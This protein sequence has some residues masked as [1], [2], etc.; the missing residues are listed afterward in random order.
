M[1][2]VERMLEEMGDTLSESLR[3]LLAAALRY[4]GEDLLSK[5]TG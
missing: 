3:D 2:K 4:R 5:Y 1:E